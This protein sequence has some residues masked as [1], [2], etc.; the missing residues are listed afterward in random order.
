MH[1]Q[2]KSNQK[3]D[4][5][6]TLIE[7]FKNLLHS[8]F[9]EEMNRPLYRN[10][11]DLQEFYLTKEQRTQLASK[12]WLIR[13]FLSCFWL[14][15]AMILKL[16]PI[17]RV[18][19]IL[20]IFFILKPNNDNTNYSVLGGIILLIILMVELKDK[21][22]AQSELQE[23]HA[24]QNALLPPKRPIVPGWDIWLHYEAAN[25]VGGDLLDFQKINE[26]RYSISL[27]DVADKGLK[28]ALTM[29]KLHA[30]L[31]ALSFESDSL[32]DLITK[33]NQISCRDNLP[34]SFA[35]LILLEIEHHSSAIRLVNA[36]H[37]PPIIIMKNN[38]REMI[39]GDP[40][41]GLTPTARYSEHKLQLKKSELLFIYSDGVTEARNEADALFGED[42]LRHLLNGLGGLSAQETGEQIVNYVDNFI[43]KAPRTD[44][45][46]MAILRPV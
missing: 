31:R 1:N 3:P 30:T 26:K 39:K 36:G 6:K 32:S 33:T 42:R 4:M 24:V 13:W 16:S 28:A 15:K 2:S 46:S 11:K 25:E 12:S 22:V 44:D 10:F 41:L 34:T 35:S 17:R 27:G 40:G 20:G 38:I 19:F 14:V 7:D 9:G 29:A 43:K 23:G 8:L 37:M 5:I 18:L 21:L 45:L